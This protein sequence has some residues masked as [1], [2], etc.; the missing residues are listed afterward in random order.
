M[1][2]SVFKHYLGLPVFYREASA[3]HFD[4][5]ACVCVDNDS[6]RRIAFKYCGLNICRRGYSF[7]SLEISYQQIA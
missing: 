7:G 5:F 1:Q 4:N 6:L 3:E 2:K